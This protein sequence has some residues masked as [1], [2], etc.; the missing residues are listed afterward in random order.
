MLKIKTTHLVLLILV[1]LAAVLGYNY[2][3]RPFYQQLTAAPEAVQ[4][5]LIASNSGDLSAVE[6]VF[7]RISERDRIGQLLAWP[8]TVG[9][10]GELGVGKLGQEELFLRELGQIKPG[11]IT[12]FGEQVSSPAAQR[13]IRV[14]KEHNVSILQPWFAVD[15]EGGKVQRFSGDGFTKLSSWHSSC[16]SDQDQVEQVLTRSAQELAA[17]GINMVLAPVIDVGPLKSYMGDRLCSSNPELVVQRVELFNRVFKARHLWPVIKHFPGIG[18]IKSDL[19]Q[20]FA[21]GRVGIEDVFVY[22]KILDQDPA[23]GVMTSHI[24]LENQFAD[25][26]C[27][28][29]PDCVGELTQNYPQ[30]L[31]IADALEMKSA[32]YLPPASRSAEIKE[33]SLTEVSQRAIMAGNNV[34]LYGPSVTYEQLKEVYDMLNRAYILDRNFREKVDASVKKIIGYKLGLTTNEIETPPVETN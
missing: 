26:P 14:I 24:G 7:N 28:L 9:E 17:V 23:I 31:V 18:G 10:S 29:S 16:D 5:N 19:H 13:A 30:P 11:V 33:L 4:T 8:I 22:R 2:Y 3:F 21:V 6:I 32:A 20:N 27:S 34:L 15:H 25:L 1:I 12:L